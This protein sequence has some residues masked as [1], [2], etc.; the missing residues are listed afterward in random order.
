VKRF[1]IAA[2]AVLGVGL[3]VPRIVPLPA[4]H[5]DRLATLRAERDALAGNDDASVARLRKEASQEEAVAW[6]SVRLQQWT[7]GLGPRWRAR[8]GDETGIGILTR[9]PDHMGDWSSFMAAVREWSRLPGVTVLAV[10]I[11]ATG[12]AGRR[13]FTRRI[14]TL[15]FAMEEISTQTEKP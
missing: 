12:P 9:E 11:E 6:S 10:E 4:T 5:A 8:S 7:G 2:I 1:G 13:Q 3:V 15:R 14:V